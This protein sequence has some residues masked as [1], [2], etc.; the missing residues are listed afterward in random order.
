M[1]KEFDAFISEALTR[2]AFPKKGQDSKALTT[3]NVPSVREQLPTKR[4]NE[5][6]LE[7]T[8]EDSVLEF[9][10]KRAV[11][12]RL[13]EPGCM[14]NIGLFHNRM[15]STGTRL[16]PVCL[17]GQFFSIE[18]KATGKKP[19]LRQDNTREQIEAA[20]GVVYVIDSTEAAKNWYSRDLHHHFGSRLMDTII[21]KATQVGA[22]AVHRCCSIAL[23]PRSKPSIMKASRWRSCRT[24][25]PPRS[26]CGVPA[27][28][29]RHRY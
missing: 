23:A 1:S 6:Q 7:Y 16:Y 4:R 24:T 12:K 17:N 25:R 27:S 29:C 10:V 26:S 28:T 14:F 9:K 2:Q 21:S 13:V 8:G 20:G 15:E 11:K 19:T 5:P 18:T 22:G 3:K